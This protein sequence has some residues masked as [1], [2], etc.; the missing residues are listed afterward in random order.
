MAN[1][2]Y[3]L[4]KGGPK[5]LAVSSALKGGAR[6]VA[7]DGQQVASLS[8]TELQTG[9]VVTLPDGSALRLQLRRQWPGTELRIARNG[10]ALPA[11]PTAAG[12]LGE[13]YGALFFVGGFNLVL[14]LVSLLVTDT[15]LSDVGVGGANIVEGIVFLIIGYFVRRRSRIALAIGIAFFALD[16]IVSFASVGSASLTAAFLVRLALLVLMQRGFGAMRELKAEPQTA[17]VQP[18]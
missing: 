5:R 15:T 3:A 7:L 11:T 1:R 14:G 9:S 4:E 13:S 8:K 2:T 10:I 17:G 6:T 18:A 12:H 16:T